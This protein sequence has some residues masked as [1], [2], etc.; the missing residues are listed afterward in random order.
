V[1]IKYQER[2][3]KKSQ[4]IINTMAT[5]AMGAMKTFG[6]N[7]GRGSGTQLDINAGTVAITFIL[8]FIYTI[9]SATGINTFKNCEALKG[10][11]LQQGLNRLLTATL[12]IALTIPFT[13]F[14]AMVSKAKIT[15]IITLVYA[16][17]GI[18]GSSI[19]LNYSMKCLDKKEGEIPRIYNIISLIVFILA[20]MVGFFFIATA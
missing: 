19:A 1:S 8:A 17:M 16:I 9:T 7:I 2:P 11:K 3:R 18:I 20:L 4:S 5:A 12:S 15:G 14:I 13:L 6:S 10:S